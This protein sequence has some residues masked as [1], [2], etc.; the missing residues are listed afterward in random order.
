MGC[1]R[2]NKGF[3]WKCVRNIYFFLF[4][5][6]AKISI[7]GMFAC[8]ESSSLAFLFG[9]WAGRSIVPADFDQWENDNNW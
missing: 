2:K 9:K 3:L 6:M 8:E 7:L 5:I 4:I 1:C